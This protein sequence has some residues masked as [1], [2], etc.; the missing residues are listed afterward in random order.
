MF[1]INFKELRNGNLHLIGTPDYVRFVLRKLVFN[2]FCCLVEADCFVDRIG[3]LGECL[4]DFAVNELLI[5]NNDLVSFV[6]LA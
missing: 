5:L 2:A 6:N 1:L 4:L 3:D